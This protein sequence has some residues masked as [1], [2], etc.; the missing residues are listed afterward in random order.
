MYAYSKCFPGPGEFI[1]IA[2]YFWT[3][4]IPRYVA[5]PQIEREVTSQSYGI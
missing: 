4:C 1:Y 3:A 5:A 2:T